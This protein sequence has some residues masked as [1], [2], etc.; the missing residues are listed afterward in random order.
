MFRFLGRLTTR[1]PWLVCAIW[2]VLGLT[3]ALIAPSWARSS[4]DDDIRFLPARCDS[5]RG[6]KLLAEAFPQ[7]IFASKLVFVLERSGAPLTET[8]TEFVEK[9]AGHVRTTAQEHPDLQIKSILTPAD[10]FIGSRLISADRACALIQVSLGTPYLAFKTVDAVEQLE[11]KAKAFH[12]EEGTAGLNLY[13]TGPAGVGRDLVKTANN[14]L[15]LTTVA[16]VLLVIV[17]L[18]LVYRAPIMALIPLVTIAL[19]VWVVLS[20]LALCTL[21]PGFYL[22]NITAVF[23]VVM[24]YGAGTDYCLFLISRYREELARGHSRRKALSRAVTGVGGALVASAGTVVCGLGMMATAEFAKV[25]TGG[26]AIGLSLIVALAASLTLTPALLQLL[27][28]AAFW[29]MPQPGRAGTDKPRRPL[30]DYLA[31]LVVRRPLMVAGVSLGLL[32]PLA[33][34]GFQVRPSYRA[35]AELSQQATSVRGL[36]ALQRHFTA[37]EVGPTTLLLESTT[38]WDSP[39]GRSLVRVLSQTLAGMENVAEV[40]SLTQ[41]LGEPLTVASRPASDGSPFLQTALG[42]L[43]VL[44][45]TPVRSAARQHYTSVLPATESVP[46]RHVTRI[47]VVLHTDPFSQESMHTWSVIQGWMR[48]ILPTTSQG[49]ESVSMVGYG[50][51]VGARDLALTTESDRLRINTLVVIGIFLILLV[52]VRRLWL[53]CLLLGTVLLS[54]YTTLGA[55]TLFATWVHARPLL[56]VDWR[57]PFFLFVTLVAVGEDYNILLISRA[58]HERKRHEAGKAMRRALSRTGSTITSCGLIMA[59]TSATL[60]LAGLTTL[61]QIGF[62][63]MLGVLLDTFIVRPLLVPAI[64]V[65]VW[66]QEEAENHSGDANPP[67]PDDQDSSTTLPVPLEQVYRTAG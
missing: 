34:L 23:A 32:V 55:T 24:L 63:L 46:T 39:D 9:L 57:V 13:L 2:L 43:A 8:D 33:L 65:W 4:Q 5:V 12:E 30:W 47:D 49:M 67:T 26:P 31:G 6:Y 48:D 40:R 58:L 22:I 19:S 64:T 11:K 38:D 28:K 50:I 45:D 60:M 17:I 37:G 56:E 52:L 20:G 7:D 1:R 14:S 36:T 51:T 10:P 15:D 41:P 16:T 53:A 18:L 59:G 21:I 3:L 66:K 54:Y 62:A 44:L 42:R 61:V 27:G 25:R 35:T 29:P